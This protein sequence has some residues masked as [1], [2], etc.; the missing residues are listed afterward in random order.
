[1]SVI[2]SVTEPLKVA[3]KNASPPQVLA[4]SG[5]TAARVPWSVQSTY[6]ATQ[7]PQA[8]VTYVKH[9]H[10]IHTWHS[11]VRPCAHALITL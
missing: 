10:M 3:S 11:F 7:G 5:S 6:I 9:G 1:M 4:L 8:Y 2:I